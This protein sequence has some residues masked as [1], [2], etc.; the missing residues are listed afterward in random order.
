MHRCIVLSPNVSF[1]L[2][3][4]YGYTDGHK[5]TESA[6]KTSSIFEATF[7]EHIRHGSPPSTI[8]C[9]MNAGPQGIPALA[10][11]LNSGRGV[12]IRARASTW[13]GIDNDT[14]CNANNTTTSTRRDYIFVT[15]TPLP[16]VASY[17]ITPIGVVP[18]RQPVLLTLG[19]HAP[20]IRCFR[21]RTLRLIDD[22]SPDDGLTIKEWRKQVATSTEKTAEDWTTIP[23][24]ATIEDR[25][26]RWLK[27]NHTG[28]HDAAGT[29]SKHRK[30]RKGDVNRYFVD[31][32]ITVS[33]EYITRVTRGHESVK[34]TEVE[35]QLKQNSRETCQIYRQ[36]ATIV[37]ML[38]KRKHS[39][40]LCDT[41]G[42]PKPLAKHN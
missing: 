36:I 20:S 9:D 40:P 32:N 7:K 17:E 11:M 6:Y 18:V 1:L 13:G 22:M 12:D 10:E 33:T 26:D 4:T 35:Q 30:Y 39:P 41:K 16:I 29:E 24:N 21:C 34:D 25:Y 8:C 38:N 37:A 5:N 23:N 27:I 14:T 15:D 3:F 42:S 28:L 2:F 31:V 19:V